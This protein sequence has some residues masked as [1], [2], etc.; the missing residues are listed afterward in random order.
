MLLSLSPAM[1]HETQPAV[2]KVSHMPVAILLMSLKTTK[3][4]LTGVYVR[5]YLED[6]SIQNKFTIL[7]GVG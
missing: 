2:H 3:G 7:D 4:A 6:N 5:I 1:L